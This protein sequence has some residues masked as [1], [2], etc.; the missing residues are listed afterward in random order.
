MQKFGP[1]N[2]YQEEE[3]YYLTQLESAVHFLLTLTYSQLRNIS[4][5]TFLSFSS[6][7]FLFIIINY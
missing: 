6:S 1:K 2:L 4:E 7:S 3:G 5:S